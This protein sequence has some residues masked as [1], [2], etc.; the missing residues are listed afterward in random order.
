ME[1]LLIYHSPDKNRP[2]IG[3]ITPFLFFKAP[4]VALC[5]HSSL[6]QAG[7]WQLLDPSQSIFTIQR[8]FP[9]PQLTNFPTKMPAPFPSKTSTLHMAPRDV[10]QGGHHHPPKP[11]CLLWP[12]RDGKLLQMSWLMVKGRNTQHMGDK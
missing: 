1:Q 11:T 2:F 7:C 9:D 6:R 3:L 4:P 12:R 10:P 5:L 8:H